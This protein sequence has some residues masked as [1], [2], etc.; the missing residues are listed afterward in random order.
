M[1]RFKLRFVSAL[2]TFVIGVVAA[3]LWLPRRP[4]PAPKP[5]E[6]PRGAAPTTDARPSTEAENPCQWQRRAGQEL[7]QLHAEYADSEKSL[8][9]EKLVILDG[10][11]RRLFNSRPEYYPCGDDTK[12]WEAK[13]AELGADLDRWGILTYSGKLLADAH[14]MNP[15]SEFRRYTLFSTVEPEHGLGVMPNVKA[16]HR[17][18]EEF[19]DGPFIGE[20]LLLI[21][22]FNKDLYMVLRD[23]LRDYKYDCFKPYT[24]RSPRAAQGS[25]AQAKAV[26][27]YEKAL[28]VNPAHAR[29]K[30]FL[31]EVKKGIVRGWSFCAD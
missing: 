18:A 13:Y 15:G 31:E 27:Y 11:I 17:Y 3:A 22:D 12:L 5:E 6:A 7:P 29:A 16:A 10:K 28:R 4:A 19:P 24:D 21:A 9:V 2:L 1:S 23:D 8:S 30:D 14:R 25:R 20:T 26:R